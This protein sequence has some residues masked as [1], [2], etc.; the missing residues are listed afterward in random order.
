MAFRWYRLKISKE[1]DL[2]MCAASLTAFMTCSF[3]TPLA[4]IYSDS[5]KSSPKRWVIFKPASLRTV[6]VWVWTCGTFCANPPLGGA[7]LTSVGVTVI[8]SGNLGNCSF[9]NKNFLLCKLP[10]HNVLVISRLVCE[11]W[12][13]KKKQKR[14][15]LPVEEFYYFSSSSSETYKQKIVTW[16]EWIMRI[17]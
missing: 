6:R 3:E 5:I 2:G 1:A 11:Q 17:V 8:S 4:V 7:A 16:I 15:V 14:R 12:Y 10:I 9:E 13:A